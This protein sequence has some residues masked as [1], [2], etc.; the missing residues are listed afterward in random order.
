MLAALA[1]T[2]AN[3]QA[4]CLSLTSGP[5]V[6]DVIGCKVLTPETAFD[7]SKE[8]Y[9]WIKDL[10]AAGKKQFYDTYRG[11]YLKG[12]VVKS[13]AQTKGIANEQGAL[14]GDTI[15][16]MILP[17]ATQ[18]NQI[19]GKRI[20]G[21]LKE[22]CCEGGGQPPCLLDTS[23]LILQP[24]VIGGAE[25]AAGDSTRTKAKQSKDYQAAEKL[26]RAKKYKDAVKLYEKARPNDEL[27]VTGFYHLAFSYREMDQ[28]KD[29]VGPLKIVNEKAQ[30]K[31]IWADEEG[32]AR[33]AQFLLARCHAKLNDPQSA[34]L[35]LNSYLLEPKKYKTEI[36][37]SLKHKDFGWIHTSKEYRDYKKEAQSK[38]NKGG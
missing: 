10:D 27:D 13:S 3:A 38:L 8:K 15:Y 31:Q 35:L 2:G 5:I 9:G 1:F 26:Y 21:N 28:C 22:V 7:L 24:Q 25:S 23:Y 12:K 17:P 30:K 19:L 36:V 16:S 14:N 33:K 4:E 29:A 20:A 34:V 18:C 37:Q 6:Y 32:T 11:T